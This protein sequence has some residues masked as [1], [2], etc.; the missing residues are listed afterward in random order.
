MYI[1]TDQIELKQRYTSDIAKEVIAFLNTSGG[2]IYI[3]INDDGEV[4]GVDNQDET[5]FK[6]SNLIH[7]TVVPDALSFIRIDI[8]NECIIR[9]QIMEGTNKPYYLKISY[10]IKRNYDMTFLQ[11]NIIVIIISI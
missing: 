5:L 4:V 11:I 6:V 10:H 2:T 1:E 3:G 8:Y 7:D 9:I